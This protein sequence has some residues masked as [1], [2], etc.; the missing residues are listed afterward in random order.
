M[1]HL[2][3]LF[4]QHTSA[5]EE[6]SDTQGLQMSYSINNPKPKDIHFTMTENRKAANPNI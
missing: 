4:I 1:N 6:I 3:S 2:C 5:Q